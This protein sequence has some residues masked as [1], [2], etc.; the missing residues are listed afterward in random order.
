MSELRLPISK[1][2]YLSVSQDE[3]KKNTNK[4]SK[5]KI[6]TEK[7]FPEFKKNDWDI[8]DSYHLSS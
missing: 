3:V 7:F 6:K 2:P 1:L 5:K 8:E 4:N